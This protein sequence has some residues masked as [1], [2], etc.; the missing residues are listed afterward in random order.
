MLWILWKAYRALF[1]ELL[2]WAVE[3]TL[4]VWMLSIQIVINVGYAVLWD[5]KWIGLISVVMADMDWR[6]DGKVLHHLFGLNYERVFCK[7]LS[8]F[9]LT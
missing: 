9:I 8:S 7:I 4:E 5:D 1:W 6:E 3:K 2:R